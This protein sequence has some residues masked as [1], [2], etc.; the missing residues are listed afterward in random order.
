M[1]KA[2]HPTTELVKE[3]RVIEV[4][5]PELSLEQEQE[6]YDNYDFPNPFPDTQD[7]PQEDQVVEFSLD[8]PQED[9]VVE[10]SPEQ[11]LLF[12]K[13]FEEKYD[14]PDPVYK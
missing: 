5:D 1:V 14:V 10:F 12:Q 9:E 6:E 13:R 2:N 8:W 7:W 11:V 4:A 3:N